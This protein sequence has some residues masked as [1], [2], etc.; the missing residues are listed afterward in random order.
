MPDYRHC[1]NLYTPFDKIDQAFLDK[2]KDYR[3][4]PP[5]PAEPDPMGKTPVRSL[6]EL[7][8]L[9]IVGIYTTIEALMTP[10]A[11]KAHGW[12]PNTLGASLDAG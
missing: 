8:A 3:V 12:G 6:D 11:Q 1:T 10:E 7:K 9:N 5:I 4:G 2:L